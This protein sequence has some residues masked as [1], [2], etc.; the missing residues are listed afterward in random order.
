LTEDS[1]FKEKYKIMETIANAVV[2]AHAPCAHD[3]LNL[4]ETKRRHLFIPTKQI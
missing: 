1:T 3:R 4:Q 2:R